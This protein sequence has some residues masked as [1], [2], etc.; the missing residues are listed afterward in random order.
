MTI[1][2]ACFFSTMI[3]LSKLSKRLTSA[4]VRFLRLMGIPLSQTPHIIG[5]ARSW[6][7]DTLCVNYL[8]C[9]NHLI[10]LELLHVYER[11]SLHIFIKTI[12]IAAESKWAVR[13]FLHS[14]EQVIQSNLILTLE[15][16]DIVAIVL[17]ALKFVAFLLNAGSDL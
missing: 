11:S 15:T 7:S 4:D 8:F 17:E 16:V 13:S 1:G 12:S 14:K 9:P 2:T 6:F 5:I 10:G 3:L